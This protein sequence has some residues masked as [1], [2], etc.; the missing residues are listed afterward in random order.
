MFNDNGSSMSSTNIKSGNT[1]KIVIGFMDYDPKMAA[2][3]A[4]NTYIKKRGG[5]TSKWYDM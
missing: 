3:S 5:R 1:A 4:R 2:I